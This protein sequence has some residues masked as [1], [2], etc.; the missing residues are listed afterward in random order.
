MNSR[1]G[2][3]I[4]DFESF[5]GS[6]KIDGVWEIKKV[7]EEGDLGSL[8]GYQFDSE[9]AGGYLYFWSNGFVGFQYMDYQTMEEIIVDSLLESNDKEVP[10]QVE[11]IMVLLTKQ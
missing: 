2:E 11:K 9:N 1:L 7:S 5:M 8:R 4:D 10:D 3:L 6:N